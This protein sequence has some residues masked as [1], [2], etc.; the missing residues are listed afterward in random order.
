MKT[1]AMGM[2][3]PCER[4]YRHESKG[5]GEGLRGGEGMWVE[6]RGAGGKSGTLLFFK[7]MAK[8]KS[9][10]ASYSP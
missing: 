8:I 1:L 3:M 9:V 5:K 10:V 2:E 7:W 4:W 6:N